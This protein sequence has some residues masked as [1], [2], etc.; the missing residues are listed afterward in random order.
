VSFNGHVAHW[1]FPTR[2][3]SSL[4][5]PAPIRLNGSRRRKSTA[6]AFLYFR[7]LA[8]PSQFAFRRG[9]SPASAITW[10]V[11]TSETGRL[12]F[13]AGIGRECPADIPVILRDRATGP[14]G[15]AAFERQFVA[16]RWDSGHCYWSFHWFSLME[17]KDNRGKRPSFILF[18]E[19]RGGDTRD[20]MGMHFAVFRRKAVSPNQVE[21]RWNARFL[22]PRRRPVTRASPCRHGSADFR[23]GRRSCWLPRTAYWFSQPLGPRRPCVGCRPGKAGKRHYGFYD[24]D[25]PAPVAPDA[26]LSCPRASDRD[27]NSRAG[28]TSGA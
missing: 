13:M 16:A 11:R 9:T 20:S 14:S 18:S 23:G 25:V 15:Q 12:L 27:R 17:R 3:E 4:V 21:L 5:P 26:T 6:V 22:A 8:E 1:S 2:A 28:Q 19:H 24:V 10:S 7:P